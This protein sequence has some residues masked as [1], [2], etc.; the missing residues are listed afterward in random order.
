MLYKAT[1]GSDLLAT[2]FCVQTDTHAGTRAKE[3]KHY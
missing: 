2:A 3:Q 1:N